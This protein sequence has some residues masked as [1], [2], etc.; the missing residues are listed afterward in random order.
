MSTTITRTT[1]F[2]VSDIRKVVENFAADFSMMAQSTGLRTPESVAKVVSDLKIL[3]EYAYLIDVT[4]YLFDAAGN[5]IRVAKYV[6]SDSASG[7]KSDRPGDS[8]WPKTEGGKLCVLANLTNEWWS[9]S[10][11][12]RQ[13]FVTK[14]GMNYGWSAAEWDTSLSGLTARA[15]QKYASNGYGWERTNYTS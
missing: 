12:D 10:D 4:L 3:A 2:T 1:T 15:G 8:L 13:S 11:A 5:K 7:W 6:V 14:T 9:K